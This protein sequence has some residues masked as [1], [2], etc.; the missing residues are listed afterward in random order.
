ME[1]QQPS[2]SEGVNSENEA[3][4]EDTEWRDEE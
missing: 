4:T 1:M 3:K 2:P